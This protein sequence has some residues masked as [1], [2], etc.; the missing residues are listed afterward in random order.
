MTGE[1]MPDA[2]LK[3]FLDTAVNRWFAKWRRKAATMTDADWRACIEECDRMIAQGPQYPLVEKVMMA[4]LYEID[5]R[6][7]GRYPKKRSLADER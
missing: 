1:P 3:A 4:L 2:T 6:Q 7:K 5:A